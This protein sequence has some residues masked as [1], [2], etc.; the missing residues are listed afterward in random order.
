MEYN[1]IKDSLQ[2][3]VDR[4]EDPEVLYALR[5]ALAREKTTDFWNDL[6]E[7]IKHSIEKGLLQ[8]DKDE[9]IP[10]D[11]EMKKYEKWLSK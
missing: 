2:K 8:A 3:L 9:L 6:P 7:E 5:N 4:I 11:Q 1:E 10:H